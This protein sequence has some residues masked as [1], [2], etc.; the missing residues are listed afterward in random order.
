M[1]RNSFLIF[2]ASIVSNFVDTAEK[3][4]FHQKK[5]ARMRRNDSN[6]NTFNQSTFNEKLLLTQLCN[7]QNEDVT[8]III[9]VDIH[10]ELV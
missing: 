7:F 10:D 1:E 2:D 4:S 3:G 8:R 5:F 6:I 9:C